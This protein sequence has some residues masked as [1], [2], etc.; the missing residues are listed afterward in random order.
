MTKVSALNGTDDTF[1]TKSHANYVTK[2]HIPMEEI[3]AL[4]NLMI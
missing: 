3:N 4:I 2:Q 1:T